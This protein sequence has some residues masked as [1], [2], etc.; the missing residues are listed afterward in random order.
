LSNQIVRRGDVELV[1]WGK[2]F[3]VFAVGCCGVFACLVILQV[4]INVCSKI[5]VSLE[6]RIGSW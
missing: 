3:E 2:A 1:D 5:I 4:G 6:K